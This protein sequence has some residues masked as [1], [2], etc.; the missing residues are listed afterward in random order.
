MHKQVNN[1]NNNNNNN[2]ENNITKNTLLK[3]SISLMM[4]ACVELGCMDAEKPMLHSHPM[5]LDTTTREGRRYL[6]VDAASSFFFFFFMTRADTAQTSAELRWIGLIRANSGRIERNGRFKSKL[7]KKKKCK[8]H[9]LNLITN[10][11][12]PKLSHASSLHSNFSSLQLSLICL[13][14]VSSALFSSLSFA[15]LLCVEFSASLCCVL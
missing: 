9:H 15:S 1:N 3:G 6:W 7:K 11:K 14:V 12:G 4:S 5:W 2:E 8:T 13:S 10:S